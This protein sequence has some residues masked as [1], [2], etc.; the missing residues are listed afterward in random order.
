MQETHE[1]QI[2]RQVL[3]SFEQ[4]LNARQ[5]DQTAAQTA[6]L[7]FLPRLTSI[8]EKSSDPQLKHT[9]IASMDRIVEKF[10]KKDTAAVIAVASTISGD[11]CLGSNDSSLRV[12]ALLCLATMLEILG[13]RFV[14]VIPH[15]FSK[16]M[17]HLS[18]SIQDNIED[19]RL[20]NA[21]YSFVSALLLHVPWMVTGAY[22]E[23]W[24]RLSHES[25]NAEMGEECDLNRIVALRLVAKQ[26]EPK[27]CFAALQKTWPSAMTEG[28]IVSA[29]VPRMLQESCKLTH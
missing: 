18:T 4:R 17:E 19:K 3:S 23:H 11:K 21:C 29:L 5:Y 1:V 6:C 9:A 2:H 7:A 27:E 25:A 12:T 13:D 15:T 22:L 20:H 14:P 10:G 24:L 16:A 8:L 26:I 28:P